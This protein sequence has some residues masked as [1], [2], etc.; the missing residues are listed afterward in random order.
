MGIQDY[1][2]RTPLHV[3]A[4]VGNLKSARLLVQNGANVNVP[5]KSGKTPLDL[6]LERGSKEVAKFLLGRTSNPKAKSDVA[7]VVC[8]PK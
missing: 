4:C 3:A 5:D 8:L 2:K 7:K 6:A 1:D